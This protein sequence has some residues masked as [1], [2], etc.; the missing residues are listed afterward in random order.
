MEIGC[1]FGA[2]TVL[3]KKYIDHFGC[4]KKYFAIDTFSGFT[5]GDIDHEI[6]VRG[7]SKKI[8]SA[9]RQNKI[10]W[11]EHSLR[12]AGVQGVELIRADCSQFDYSRI[13]EIA[14]CLVDV[15]L[16]KPVIK[17]LEAIRPLLAKGAIVVVDDC[18]P[19]PM[20]DG[21]LQAYVEFMEKHGLQQEI[22]CEKY[23]I[24]RIAD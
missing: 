4:S 13:G 21:A 9:F 10:G 5:D 22:V 17:A 3:L 8:S 6:N 24:I 1:A 20:W 23:G 19:H 12:L 14:F 2:S 18:Q 16:Y 7:K 11:V 15:D